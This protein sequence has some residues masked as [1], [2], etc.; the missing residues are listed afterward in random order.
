MDFIGQRWTQL[1]HGKDY[2]I[3][4]VAL[5]GP[6]RT[7]LAPEL[8]DTLGFP[9]C[10]LINSTVSE[11]FPQIVERIRARGDEI[12]GHG[13]TNSERQADFP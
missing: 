1:E 9:L 10:H 3:E 13:R 2:T 6:F 11:R 7:P 12:V 8:M 4:I 5:I